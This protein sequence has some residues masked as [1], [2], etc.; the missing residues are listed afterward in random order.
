MFLKRV[1]KKL[2]C[3]KHLPFNFQNHAME[4]NISIQN[5]SEMTKLIVR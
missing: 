2:A 1:E 4:G 3:I 5:R